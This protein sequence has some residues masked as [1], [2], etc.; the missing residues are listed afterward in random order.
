MVELAGSVRRHDSPTTAP[1]KIGYLPDNLA[2]VAG[3]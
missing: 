3:Q 2:L 1:V